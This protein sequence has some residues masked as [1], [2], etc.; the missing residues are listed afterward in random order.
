MTAV[1]VAVPARDEERSVEPTLVALHRAVA[2]ARTHGWLTEARVHVVAHRCA[3]ETAARARAFFA[4]HGGGQV[5]ED[6]DS[7]TVGAVRDRAVRA[8]LPALHDPADRTWVLSTDA[9]T[10]VPP[11]W[12][13]DILRLAGQHDAHAV[14]G[15]AGLD[16]WRGTPAGLAA[17]AAVLAGGTRPG[18]GLRQHDHVY[19]ANLAV[20]LDAYLDAGGFPDVPHGE[21]QRLVDLLAT[22]GHRLLRTREVSVTTSGRMHGRARDGLA[23]Y[24]RLL[25][26]A[27]GAPPTSLASASANVV[28]SRSSRRSSS[29]PEPTSP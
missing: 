26:A 12:V 21:D 28:A 4:R 16:R 27:P 15:L 2:T 23:D 9:D 1:L 5:T 11:T 3:D 13:S 29:H 10:L 18:A 25:D 24:L 7:G 22:R 14:V 17:Y 19:G 8:V 6:H 20:R